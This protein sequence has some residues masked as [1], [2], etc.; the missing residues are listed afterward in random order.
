MA[1]MAADRDLLFGLLALQNGLIDQGQLVAAFQAWTRDKGRPLAEHLVDRGDLDADER[2]GRRGDGRTPSQEALR[3]RGKEPRLDPR[4][5]IDARAWLDRRPQSRRHHRQRRQRSTE[6]DADDPRRLLRRRRTA[7]A[8]GFASF[9]PTPEAAWAKST[10]RSTKNCT[11][12]SHSRRSEQHADD[13]TAARFLLEAEVTGGLE[14]PGIVPVYG[15][16]AYPRRSPVLRHAVHP[17]GQSRGG[18]RPF[19]RRRRV[20]AIRASGACELRQLL[21]RFVDVCDAMEY[22]HSRGVLHRD[23]KPGNIM[24]GKYG[25]TLVVD[26]G[27]AKVVGREEPPAGTPRSGRCRRSRPAARRR[28]CRARRSARPQYMSPEQADGRAGGARAGQRRVQPGRHAL[29]AADR[30]GA[31]RGRTSRRACCARA[32]G[33]FRPPRQVDRGVDAAAGG[34]LPEGDGAG[35]RGP[36]CLAPCLADDIEHWLADEPVAAVKDTWVTRLGRRM[37]RNRPIVAAVAALMVTV[38][39]SLAV[40]TFL[41]TREQR[42]TALQRDI[43]GQRTREA[44]K[45]A[46]SLAA[47]LYMSRVNP[48]PARMDTNNVGLMNTLLEQCP[49]RLRGWEWAYCRWLGHMDRLTLRAAEDEPGAAERSLGGVYGL[50]YSPDGRWLAS[51]GADNRK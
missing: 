37:R 49:P 28:R 23:L 51:S 7:E 43:A 35:A 33:R 30:Q 39:V 34:D 24:L 22:A 29:H 31:V 50:A 1:A 2:C 9:A 40:S 8:S 25:E 46:A 21:G 18:H 32:A 11:A 41:I 3:R 44:T 27:L 13:P 14:H 47:S 17:R 26:W 38:M 12:K 6:P 36:L 4:R 48:R 10:W 5:P 16:G 19:P 42:Q 20:R 45:A 15:L